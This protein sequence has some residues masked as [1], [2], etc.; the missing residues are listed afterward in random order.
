MLNQPKQTM[1]TARNKP[2]QISKYR[3]LHGDFT[4]RFVNTPCIRGARGPDLFSSEIMLLNRALRA[5]IG[6]CTSSRVS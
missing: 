4:P 6:N 3:L 2:S 1:P 5:A